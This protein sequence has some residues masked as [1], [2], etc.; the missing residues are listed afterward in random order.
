MKYRE[1][2][3]AF[4]DFV[5]DRYEMVVYCRG[6][7]EC[8]EPVLDALESDK[9]HF[10]HRLYGDMVLFEN[11]E[12]SMKFYNFL[13]CGDRS[14]DNTI[15]LDAGVAVYALNMY[16]GV[17]VEPLA[18]TPGKPSSP[19]YTLVHVAHFLEEMRSVPSVSKAFV[20]IILKCLHEPQPTTEEDPRGMTKA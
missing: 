7:R 17:P 3:R 19:D 11:A 13:L 2:L 20:S 8:C 6:R 5:G 14:E 18:L 10:A 9:K 15:I 4:L 16:N 1:G 12:Y